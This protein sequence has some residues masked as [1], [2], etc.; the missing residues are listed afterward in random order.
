MN[1]ERMTVER[2]EPVAEQAQARRSCAKRSAIYNC[3]YI[4]RHSHFGSP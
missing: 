3:T 2:D 4:E 1:E